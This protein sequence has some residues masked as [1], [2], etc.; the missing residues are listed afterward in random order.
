MG[1]YGAVEDSILDIRQDKTD[2]SLATS[3]RDEQ[4]SSLRGDGHDEKLLPEMLL[5]NKKGHQLF[6]QLHLR[7][8][9]AVHGTFDDGLRWLFTLNLAH[10]KKGTTNN[11]AAIPSPQKLLLSLGATLGNVTRSERAGYVSRFAAVLRERDMML[12]SLDGTKDAAA[13]SNA[14]NDTYGI[15]KA[16]NANAINHANSILGAEV[17]KGEEWDIR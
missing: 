13:V 4:F 11:A 9:Q 15:S 6:E 2:P 14:Y 16:F 17:F 8:H 12:V 3:I 5:W 7:G 1:S 10:Q